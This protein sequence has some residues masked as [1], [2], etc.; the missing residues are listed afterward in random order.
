MAH[1]KQ[2]V[3]PV[4]GEIPKANGWASKPTAASQYQQADYR[5]P[6]R[7]AVPRR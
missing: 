1:K 5:S 7:H 4:T 6:A 2:A 3:V